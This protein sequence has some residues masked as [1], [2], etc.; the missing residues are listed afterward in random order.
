M[1]YVG[2]MSLF[3]TAPGIPEG[4]AVCNGQVLRVADPDDDALFSVVFGGYGGDGALTFGLPD[5]PAP[6][7][8]V[9]WCIC[10]EGQFPNGG[11][12]PG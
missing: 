7:P 5:L 12:L 10:V 6:A 2:S 9:Q 8:G 4:W 3:P 1:A 11:V